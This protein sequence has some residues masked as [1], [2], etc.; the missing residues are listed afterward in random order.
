MVLPVKVGHG[1]ESSFS[2]PGCCR[3]NNFFHDIFSTKCWLR[4]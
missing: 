3:R 4:I 2:L 1:E